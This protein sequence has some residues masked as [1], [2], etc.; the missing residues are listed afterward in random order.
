[1]VMVVTPARGVVMRPA[2]HHAELVLRVEGWVVFEEFVE[3]RVAA[4]VDAVVALDLV[5][6]GAR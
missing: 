1:M 4:L 2:G 6:L 3:E 5:V